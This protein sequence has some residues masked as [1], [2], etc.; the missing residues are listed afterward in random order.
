LSRSGSRSH[1]L[2]LIERV[3]TSRHGELA[4]LGRPVRQSGWCHGSR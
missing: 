2:A 4:R 1:S 3:S